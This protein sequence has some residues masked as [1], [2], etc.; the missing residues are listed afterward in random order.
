MGMVLAI[1]GILGL[2]SLII[3]I[4][5]VIFELTFII[6][7]KK[8][9]KNSYFY[10]SVILSVLTVLVGMIFAFLGSKVH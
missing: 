9:I 7:V 3:T 4:F 10:T 8:E 6:K 2:G 1:G 5:L